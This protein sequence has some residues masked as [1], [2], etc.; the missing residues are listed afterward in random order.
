MTDLLTW[1]TDPLGYPFMLRGLTAALI[2]G[3]VCA[4][5]GTYI[6]LR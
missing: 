1:L 2:V 3:I 5:L 4:V 6:V